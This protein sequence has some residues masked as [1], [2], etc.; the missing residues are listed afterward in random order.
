MSNTTTANF[1]TEETAKKL[2][3]R[4]RALKESDRGR[5]AALKRNTGNSLA[6]SRGCFWFYEFVPPWIEENN[7][8][9]E[10]TF[11]VATLIPHNRYTAEDSLPKALKRIRPNSD[12]GKASMDRRFGILLDAGYTPGQDSELVF[13]LGQII[14]LLESKRV[15][16]NWSQLLVDL[17]N[18]NNPD[19]FIQKRWARAYFSAENLGEIPDTTNSDSSNTNHQSQEEQ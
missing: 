6:E 2:V 1:I 12:Q 3:E 15:G 14:Q 16:V 19:K 13:R 5:F 18:W 7:R 9:L 11:L 8:L 4:I 10:T 17:T